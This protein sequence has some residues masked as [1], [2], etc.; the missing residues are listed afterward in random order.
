MLP[1]SA[2]K[3]LPRTVTASVV[4]NF[5]TSLN[6]AQKARMTDT[7]PQQRQVSMAELLY[8]QSRDTGP[9]QHNASRFFS[10][11]IISPRAVR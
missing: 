7:L 1:S 11:I 5:E 2:A 6:Q 8:S 10:A 3:P 4:D 9:F